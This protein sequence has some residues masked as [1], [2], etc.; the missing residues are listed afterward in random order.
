MQYAAHHTHKFNNEHHTRKQ[1]VLRSQPHYIL[2]QL[3]CKTEI[4]PLFVAWRCL[5]KKNFQTF[6]I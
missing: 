1:A 4:K 5:K 3:H 2:I 6:R